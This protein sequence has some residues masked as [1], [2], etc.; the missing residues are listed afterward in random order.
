M[1]IDIMRDNGGFLVRHLLDRGEILATVRFCREADAEE[2]ALLW[3]DWTRAED[4]LRQ[5]GMT[6]A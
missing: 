4:E 5:R 1:A 3:R 2:F 6:A